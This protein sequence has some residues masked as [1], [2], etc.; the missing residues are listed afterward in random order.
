MS[1]TWKWYQPTDES[2]LFLLDTGFFLD[3]RSKNFRT[4]MRSSLNLS[5]H[6]FIFCARFLSSVLICWIRSLP[7]IT[8]YR[9]VDFL[10]SCSF[11]FSMNLKICGFVGNV[12]CIT[13]CIAS[14]TE[15]VFM[16]KSATEIVFFSF[17]NRYLFTNLCTN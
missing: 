14:K 11:K 8:W 9:S 5:V 3:T 10:A 12:R 1:D 13:E 2:D 6:S 7:S 16:S 4:V 15:V 17:C